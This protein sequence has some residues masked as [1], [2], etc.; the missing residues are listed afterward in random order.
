[1]K[2][3]FSCCIFFLF[4]FLFLSSCKKDTFIKS[5]DAGL[6]ITSDSIK[7]DTV[8]TT[9]GS[10]TRSFKII[11]DNNQKLL[12]SKIQLAGGT[13]SPY[14]ININGNQVNE[15]ENIEIAANDSIY[16]FVSVF[17]NPTSANLPF[18]ISDSILVS[19]NGNNRFVQLEAYGKNAHF[20]T[21]TLVSGNTT[22]VNDLP[23]VIL[24][25]LQID[26][27]ASLT[28]EAGCKIYSH[29]DAPFLVDGTLKVTGTKSNEVEFAGDRLDD[30]YKDIPGGWPG[31]YL[32]ETSNDNE[33]TFAIIKNAN[34]AIVSSGPSSN[35]NPK[36]LLHQCIDDNAFEAGLLAYNSSINADNTLISNCGN[37]LVIQL[38]GN[39]TFTNCTVAAFSNTYLLHS[40]PVLQVSDAAELNGMLI[41][42][43]L[44][45]SFVNC[46]FW[47]DD[48]SV[49]DEVM[50]DKQGGSFNVSLE[51][52]LYKAISDPANTTLTSVIKNQDPAFDSIDVS[53]KYYDFRTTKDP[54][55]PGINSGMIVALP[56]DLD[57]KNRS[58]GLPDLGSYEKQ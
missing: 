54:F 5:I 51:N 34:R 57:N 36:L 13:N 41:T 42:D 21:N 35:T 11:N 49:D 31:I 3:L 2:S 6:T 48:G 53:N 32:R 17:V 40:N 7:F 26:T 55:A 1:M 47:G 33:I 16:I 23:Y 20:L 39:Y 22:W 9:T 19:Y 8:F 37:N 15:E 45:A 43:N 44:A 10:V 56:T 52:C 12:V 28:I 25:S 14:K 50:V 30:Y 58:V 18:I 27:T 38:G 24:G 29:A 46:I 4:F